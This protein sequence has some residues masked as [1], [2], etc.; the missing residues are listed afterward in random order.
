MFISMETSYPA[1]M[2]DNYILTVKADE[3]FTSF[4]LVNFRRLNYAFNYRFSPIE[5]EQ[6]THDILVLNKLRNNQEVIFR[7]VES[8]GFLDLQ[9]IG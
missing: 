3:D 8:G 5:I 4:E 2:L 9:E 6:V 1:M 7:V